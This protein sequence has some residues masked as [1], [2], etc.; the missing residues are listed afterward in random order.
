MRVT[1]EGN[2]YGYASGYEYGYGMGSHI[3]MLQN[4]PCQW[5]IKIGY[6]LTKSLRYYQPTHLHYIL[7]ILHNQGLILSN[8]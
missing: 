8:C 3:H 5:V 7:T 6:K 4:K 2:G 1:Y